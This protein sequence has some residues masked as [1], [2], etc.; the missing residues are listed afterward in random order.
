MSFTINSQQKSFKS[1]HLPLK[2][3]IFDPTFSR[4]LSRSTSCS[5]RSR[6]SIA[7]ESFFTSLIAKSTRKIHLSQIQNQLTLHGFHNNSFL[8]TKFIAR[9]FELKEIDHARDVFDE[10]PDRNVFLWNAVIKG[11]SMQKMFDKVIEMYSAMQSASVAPDAFT[12]PHVLKACGELPALGYGRALHS[13]IL[14]H[15]FGN[16]VFLQNGLLSLYVKCEESASARLILDLLKCKDVI[17]W[18]LIISAYVQKGLPTEALRIFKNMRESGVQPDWIASISALK[19]YSDIGDLD[20]GR[21]LHSLVIRMGYD[22][23]SDLRVALTSLYAKCGEATAARLLLDE[24]ESED[25]MLWNSIISGLAKSG[26]AAEALELFSEMLCRDIRPDAV[27]IQSSVVACS[28]LGSLEKAKMM[29]SYVSDSRYSHDVVIRTALIDMYAKCGSVEMARRVFDTTAEKD[30]VV[31]SAMITSYALHGWGRHALALFHEMVEAGECPNEVTFLGLITACSRSGL[32]E[33]GWEVFRSMREG[34]GVE[35]GPRHY[36]GVVDML[37]RAGDLGRA[38]RFIEGM[39]VEPGASVWGALLSACE[40]HRD[41]GLGERAAERL[42]ALD[43]LD[44]GRCVVLSNLYASAGR[45]DGVARVR[46]VMRSRGACK[47]SGC[48]VV[49]VNGSGRGSSEVEGD[50]RDARPAGGRIN[51]EERKM[52]A[53][54]QP[55]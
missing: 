27:T 4:L 23:E 40:V 13:Q 44:T 20:Q 10:I 49:E 25:V 9:S 14:R 33:E 7:A 51:G 28:Q 5:T 17:S 6:N 39:D 46:E 26:H 16:D 18:T 37:G 15:G 21:C 31:W 41:V 54:V 19:A 29:E 55:L 53:L 32:V 43:A 35:P 2:N 12:F 24:A 50:V 47:D 1:L 11:Y 34:Y 45:W 42:L 8:I 52:V 48:S 30:V 22:L 36:A 3:F 38:W